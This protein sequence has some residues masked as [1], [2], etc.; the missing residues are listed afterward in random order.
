MLSIPATGAGVERLFNT[1]RDICHYRR[2]R[3]NATT[4]QELMM[5]LCTVRF[6]MQEEQFTFLKEFFSR[7]EIEA[8]NEERED[9]PTQVDIDPISDDE[10]DTQE[11]EEHSK[12]TEH[13]VVFD[14]EALPLPT[15]EEGNTSIRV[16]VRARKRL[17]REDD[18]YTY[19]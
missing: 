19:Y 12:E 2:G 14:D 7:D 11:Q 8:A 5:F 4:I 16:S 9:S 13:P 17:R 15:Q 1:A 3:L 6:D 18:Q 10:E